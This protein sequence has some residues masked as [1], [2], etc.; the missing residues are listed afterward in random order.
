MPLRLFALL[1][2]HEKA[3]REEQRVRTAFF[4]RSSRGTVQLD[5]CRFE[6]R[7]ACGREDFAFPESLK[8]VLTPNVFVCPAFVQRAISWVGTVHQVGARK[9]LQGLTA[10][11]R[12][13]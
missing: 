6:L 11:E 12:I 13:F 2:P 5:E 8:C 9:D 4:E 10:R 1:G 3:E 7:V